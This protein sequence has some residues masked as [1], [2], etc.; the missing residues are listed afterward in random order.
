MFHPVSKQRVSWYCETEEEFI[1][2][3]FDLF[4]ESRYLLLY[5]I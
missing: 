5:F 4:A 3:C 2:L 1:W